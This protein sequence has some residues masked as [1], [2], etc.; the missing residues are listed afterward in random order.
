MA[1]TSV[2]RSASS[3]AFR[4]IVNELGDD[5]G[6]MPIALATALHSSSTLSGAL[7]AASQQLSRHGRS[8]RIVV[9]PDPYQAQGVV[10]LRYG[11]PT[12]D[13]RSRQANDFDLG[14]I[15]RILTAL[16]GRS[17][18]L[19]SV[20]LPY[21]APAPFSMYESFFE[22][23]VRDRRPAALFRIPH[24]VLTWPIA[25]TA[26]RQVREL[27]LTTLDRQLP[28]ARAELSPQVAAVV[29][30]MLGYTVPDLGMVADTLRAHRRT[31]QRRLEQEG[32]SLTAIVDD[33]RRREAHRYLTVTD[34]PMGEIAR[35][36]GLSSPSVFT[37]CCRRWWGRTPSAVRARRTTPGAVPS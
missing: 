23:P 8:L 32:T 33:V 4:P 22:A 10:A 16:A 30:R 21:Q 28:E 3:Q 37:R 35:R 26:E 15:H 2:A 5:P 27:A 13:R 6:V 14:L 25:E 19:R 7:H 20:E 9:V 17:Y 31:L 34:V 29:A 24:S 36:L 12:Y 18:G 11:P 1:D